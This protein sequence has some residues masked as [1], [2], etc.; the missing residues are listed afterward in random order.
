MPRTFE[1]VR[2]LAFEGGGVLGI[3][4]LPVIRELERQGVLQAATGFAGTSAGAITASLLA[5]GA[6]A[7]KIDQITRTTAWS[8]F[9]GRELAV[10]KLA[11]LITLLGW[12][13]LDYPRSWLG[14]QVVSLGWPPEVTFRDLFEQT[15]RRLYVPATEESRGKIVVFGPEATPDLP[16]AAAVLASMAIPIYWPPVEISGERYSDGGLTMN[17]P[18]DVFAAAPV[19]SVLGLRLESD[20]EIKGEMAE[21]RGVVGRALRLAII[22]RNA[23]NQMHIPKCFWDAGRVLVIDTGDLSA[24][25]FSMSAD[26]IAELLRR[27]EEAVAVWLSQG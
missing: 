23:A 3:A 7:S 4:Y 21:V 12:N 5:L 25:E 19:E 26:D 27:G 22:A 14:E 18:M 16:I 6:N 17:H 8:R 10:R 1:G 24:T 13:S 11:R 15:G 2:N 9:P 20:R